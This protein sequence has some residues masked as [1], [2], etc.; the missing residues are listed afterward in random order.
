[1]YLL[2]TNACI[3]ILNNSSPIL[4]ERLKSVPPSEVKIC[5]IVKSELLYGARKSSRISE[6]LQI[7]SK[8]FTVIQSIPYDD[9]CAEHYGMIRA[10]LERTG[11]PIGPYDLMIAGVARAHD[12]VLITHNIKEFN[13]V[14]G[15]RV[16]DWESYI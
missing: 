1:M 14:V 5:S 6:N 15:L 10:D 8:F 3:K 11:S 9:L 12:F 2:D 7:L 16:E 13:R 4:I